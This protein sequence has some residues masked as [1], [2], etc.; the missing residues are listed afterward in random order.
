[1]ILPAL[2]PALGC[3]LTSRGKTLDVHWYTPERIRSQ[4]GAAEKQAVGPGSEKPACD[5]RLASVTSGADLGPRI[6]FGD[7]Q[8]RVGQYEDLHWTERP[9]HYMRRA[10]GRSLFEQ[11][12]FRRVLT[13]H[14]STLNV[15][16]LDFEEVKTPTLHAARIAVRIV[17]ASDQVLTER[18]V[19]V[20][21]PV[22][23]NSFEDFVATMASVLEKTADEVARAAQVV[24]R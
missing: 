20:T 10:L 24:C 5:L 23:G 15:E 21:E 19:V 7:G 8:Y 2:A 9:E 14:A 1:M 18:T 17:V 13:G 4:A 12:S 3:A 11:G 6:N 22:A 16:L